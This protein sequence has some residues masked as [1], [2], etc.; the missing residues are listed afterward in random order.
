MGTIFKIALDMAGSTF[1]WDA[2]FSFCQP[3]H[4]SKKVAGK[5]KWG[6]QVYKDDDVNISWDKKVSSFWFKN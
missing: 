6:E 5:I 4:N 3:A 2:I 1:D